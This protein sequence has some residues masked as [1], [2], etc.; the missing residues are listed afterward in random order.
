MEK[1]EKSGFAIAGFIVSICANLLWFAIW[2]ELLGFIFSIVG[3]IQ[4]RKKR[5]SGRGLA[6]AGLLISFWLLLT[7]VLNIITK[8]SI[9]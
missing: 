8:G 3:L 9:V 1:K 6:I 5:M 7:V 2:P 4:T